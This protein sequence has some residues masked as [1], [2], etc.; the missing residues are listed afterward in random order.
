[1]SLSRL[2]D[3]CLVP[4]FRLW[5]DGDLLQNAINGEF[6]TRG[7]TDWAILCEKEHR[8]RILVVWTGPA[9]CPNELP[10]DGRVADKIDRYILAVSEQDVT[11]LDASE[12]RRDGTS[13]DQGLDGRQVRDRL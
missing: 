6:A 1:M 7:R 3:S 9:S 5:P 12:A 13:R 10:D 11:G 4:Q 2:T 8:S